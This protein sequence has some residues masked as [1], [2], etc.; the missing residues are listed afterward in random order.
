MASGRNVAFRADFEQA[1]GS[2]GRV[3]VS[4]VLQLQHSYSVS[5]LEI[6]EMQL[7]RR[8]VRDRG[9]L[10]RIETHRER[11][12]S[13]GRNHGGAC[14]IELAVGGG[15]ADANGFLWRVQRDGRPLRQRSQ[16]PLQRHRQRYRHC[17]G[18]FSNSRNM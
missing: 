4:Q 6:H 12:G 9:Q 8:G 5:G 18:A 2:P 7:R 10:L 16:P 17:H 13:Q 15:K 11:Q 1:D 3:P 14:H